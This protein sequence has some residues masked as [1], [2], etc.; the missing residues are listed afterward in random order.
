MT[1]FNLREAIAKNKA[2]FFSSINENASDT[3]EK[4]AKHMSK[5]ENRKFTV[6]PG[7]VDEK[8]FDLDIDG[9]EYEGG[10]YLIDDNGDIINVSMGNKVYGNVNQLEESDLMKS[11]GKGLEY[12]ATEEMIRDY[13]DRLLNNLKNSNHQFD[14]VEDYF[15]F[16]LRNPKDLPEPMDYNFFKN[17]Y[18]DILSLA[19]TGLDEGKKSKK[20]LTE[21]VKILDRQADLSQAYFDLEVDGKEMS[22]TYWDYDEVFDK[23]TYEEV[24]DMIEKQL[25]NTDKYGFPVDPQLTPEQKEEIAQV[26]LKDL[27][28]N[29]SWKSNLKGY[30][31]RLE[32]KKSYYKD[33]EA[34]DAEHIKALEKDMKDDKKSSKMKKSEL[35]AKIKEMVLAEMNLDIQNT[36]DEYDFLS[37]KEIKE[38][39][40]SVLP[41]RIP[42]FI[43][44]IEDIKEEYHGVVGSDDVF[45]GLDSAIEA[46]EELLMNSAEIS[47]AKEE[48]VDVEDIDME[49]I[50]TTDIETSTEVDP[51]VKAV[52]DLLTQAQAAAQALGDEK[53][54][55]QIGNTITFFTR[56]HVVDKGAVSEGVNE[57]KSLTFSFDYSADEDD[58]DYIQGLLKDARV[59]AIA[60]PGFESDETVIKAKNEV[61]LRKAKKIIQ[62]NGFKI[63]KSVEEGKVELNEDLT[64][65]ITILLAFLIGIP[66][67]PIVGA[68]VFGL[69]DYIFNGLPDQ[70]NEYRSLKSYKGS[71]KQEKVL[72]LAK[73]IEAKLSPG[74]KRYLK[75]LVNRIGASKLEDKAREYRELD[76]YASHEKNIMDRGLDENLNTDIEAALK[77]LPIPMDMEEGKK[78]DLNESMFPLFKRIMLL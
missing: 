50:E 40:W 1:K 44:A 60:Q 11:V 65:T 31:T 15:D 51:D 37:E 5:K 14:D 42:E 68:L 29:P 33:A 48:E 10:S 71:D 45:N 54:T 63:Y 16:Y 74:K 75:T 43:K 76:R 18:D 69:V 59:D 3:A 67:V 2:T 34:D 9:L 66:G 41:K 38:G 27:R 57:A 55:D 35:K 25:I 46:A 20:N 53:L 52:Q 73:E 77:D 78:E 62:A 32:N 28:T 23:P 21:S 49:D 22:F 13:A 72:A 36:T 56:T 24:M 64:S 58:V 70:Y 39:V 30:S 7:S 17:N 61:E 4:F 26:V 12:E 8:S 6:T 47:E 19:M